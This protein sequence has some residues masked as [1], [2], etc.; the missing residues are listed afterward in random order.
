MRAALAYSLGRCL[1]VEREHILKV[2]RGIHGMIGG[3][4]GAT[5]RFGLRRTTE[6]YKM[7]KLD[8]SRQPQ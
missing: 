4:H 1:E 6:L 7:E 8:I 5:A 3:L 2:L